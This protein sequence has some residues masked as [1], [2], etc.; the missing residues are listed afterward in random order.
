MSQNLEVLRLKA[1]PPPG[2]SACLAPDRSHARNP[3]SPLAERSIGLVEVAPH[4]GHLH[5][6]EP[7]LVLPYLIIKAPHAGRLALPIGRS[8]LLVG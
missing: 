3:S 6:W 1:L 4:D 2:R 8:L 7:A 5:L